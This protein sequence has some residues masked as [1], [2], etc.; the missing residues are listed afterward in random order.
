MLDRRRFL[1]G[2]GGLVTAAFVRKATA[3][4]RKVGEPLVLPPA[5]RPE[6][7]LYVLDRALRQVARVAGP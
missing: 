7:T 4:S 2:A 1:I 3:F 6:E 5:K